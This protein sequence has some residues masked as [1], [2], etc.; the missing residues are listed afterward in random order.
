MSLSKLQ[1]AY[2]QDKNVTLDFYTKLL[3]SKSKFMSML[4]AHIL[5]GI[6]LKDLENFHESRQL[7]VTNVNVE[8]RLLPRT[9]TRTMT[10]TMIKRPARLN[11]CV[12]GFFS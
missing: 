5:C 3:G 4:V 2:G 8:M 9:M 1:G 6:G 7:P 11:T 12:R 10:R